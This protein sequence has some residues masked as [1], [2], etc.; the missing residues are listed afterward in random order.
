MSVLPLTG[1]QTGIWLAQQ[2]EPD[3][4][5]YTIGCYVELPAEPPADASVLAAAVRRAVEEAESLHVV[6]APE[7]LDSK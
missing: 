6:V 3:S 5:A 4:P 1:A 7:L 2:F